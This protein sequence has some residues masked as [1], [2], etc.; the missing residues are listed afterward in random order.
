[1]KPRIRDLM[2]ADDY[3][4]I[5]AMHLTFSNKLIIFAQNIS[6]SRNLLPCPCHWRCKWWLII[7]VFNGRA[8]NSYKDILSG[9]FWHTIVVR[10]VVCGSAF[11]LALSEIKGMVQMWG[12]YTTNK[13]TH[14][15]TRAFWYINQIFCIRYRYHLEWLGVSLY[16]QQCCG[17]GTGTVGTVT[18][19]LVE[20]EP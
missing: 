10:D 2:G 14:T 4:L 12:I 19:W 17:T 20:P 18:F 7:V 1:M 3:F 13:E 9:L 11:N 5:V 8:E 15:T 6:R 16:F